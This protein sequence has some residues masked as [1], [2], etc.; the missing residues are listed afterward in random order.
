MVDKH[1]G[2]PRGF[3]FVYFKDEQGMKDAVRDMHDK[4]WLLLYAFITRNTTHAG[5]HADL[6]TEDIMA[7]HHISSN[8]ARLSCESFVA[9]ATTESYNNC[10]SAAYFFA[11]PV[12]VGA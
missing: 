4:V 3:G 10:W 6:M 8:S 5:C 12:V 1:T 2:R 11:P 9:S 7:C